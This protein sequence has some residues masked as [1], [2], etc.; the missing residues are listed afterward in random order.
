MCEALAVQSGS[1]GSCQVMKLLVLHSLRKPR[2]FCTTSV[3]HTAYIKMI[4]KAG[5]FCLLTDAQRLCLPQELSPFRG[6]LPPSLQSCHQ[7]PAL[8]AVFP[9]RC[10]T[11]VPPRGPAGRLIPAPRPGAVSLPMHHAFWEGKYTTKISKLRGGLTF[12]RPL[13]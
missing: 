3:S 7:D 13:A 1:L 9:R 4:A 10:P 12:E 5:T 8:P 6:P 2:L 11:D